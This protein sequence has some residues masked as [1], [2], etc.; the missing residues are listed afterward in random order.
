VPPD[1][2]RAE[3]FPAF[4]SELMHNQNLV[5]TAVAMVLRQRLGIVGVPFSLV[6]HQDAADVF[7]VETDIH[8]RAMI[9]EL[10][11]H[12]IVEAGLMGVASLTQNIGE[13]K[14]YSAIS[15]FRDEELPLF[16]HKLDF[17][18]NTASSQNKED[19]F[20]R[21]VEIGG[22]PQFSADTGVVKVDKLLK[23]RDSSEAREFRDWLTGV[24]QS[25]DK[26]IK[27]HIAGLRARAGLAVGGD[28]GKV[29]RF[30]VTGV[31]GLLTPVVPATL[32]SAFDQFVLDKLLPRSGIAAF[33][34]E[35]YPSIFESRDK[36]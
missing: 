20:R 16:R 32:L 13:M 17:L 22:L 28:T 5:K 19:S 18:A 8:H 31:V 15:G 26:E 10:E 33:I 30:L 1:K 24:G 6:V 21:V 3:L 34:N 9:S 11:G 12:K 29:M 4:Q 14:Y 25:T 27:D 7:M 36:R 35:L 23:V 2:M